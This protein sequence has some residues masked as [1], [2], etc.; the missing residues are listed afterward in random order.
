MIPFGPWHPDKGGIN[1]QVCIEAINCLPGTAG[2]KP[3]PALA[4]NSEALEDDPLGACTVLDSD[5]EVHSFAGTEL[6][7]WRLGSS[8]AWTDVSRESGD[9][10]YSDAGEII[11]D[12][13][14]DVIYT[15][16]DLIYDDASDL[17][18][19]DAG[20]PLYTT[21]TISYAVAGGERWRFAAFGD[22]V[23]AVA[24]T[25]APQKFV[26][27]ASTAFQDLGGVPPNARYIAVVRDFVFLGGIVNNERR[28][29][30]SGLNNA[31]HWTAGSQSSDY[32]DFPDGGPVRGILGGEVAYV[33]QS[34]KVMRGTFQPGSATIFNFDEVQGGRGLVAPDSLV[35]LG[36]MAFYLGTDGLYLFDCVGGSAKP[37]GVDKW[38]DWL[39]DD[40]KGGTESLC[41]GGI[42]PSRRL[43]LLA[44]VP[45]GSVNNTL[46]RV[47]A[48]DW[49]KDEASIAVDGVA[50]KV[51]ANW[52]TSGTTIDTMNSYGTLDA[53]P[54]SLDSPFW[55]GGSAA[56]GIFSTAN[57]LN[58]FA[59]ANQAATIITADGKAPGRQ[60]IRATRPLIDTSSVT[61]AVS[62]RERDGDSIVYGNAESMEDIGICP[63]HIA[64]DIGRAKIITTAGA[65]WTLLKGIETVNR[66]QGRR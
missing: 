34:G 12:D 43:Y 25:D 14:T 20:S 11:Y 37:L 54:F 45:S 62:M 18:Y 56:L 29:Q 6:K 21:D 23:I 16:G 39:R 9:V 10:L 30:W 13:T 38:A 60:F 8:G 59:G 55:R 61:V 46:T 64:G 65:A 57:K 47:L 24:I 41:L 17:I 28:V 49:A 35:K 7:L 44:Y 19:D 36:N 58:Y 1:T 51:I 63:A 53:L 32:Q 42:D 15:A 33:F 50:V 27:N 31:E 26:L 40:I 5:G 3:S 66:Q 52:L 4:A 22:T 48:Y 2:F